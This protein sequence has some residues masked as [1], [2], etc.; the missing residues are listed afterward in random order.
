MKR[1]LAALLWPLLAPLAHAATYT[2]PGALPPGCTG[3]G[4][5]Y[6]C[7]ALS[8]GYNDVIVINSPKP[9]TLTINGN[10]S[11]DTSQ[12]RSEERRVGKEC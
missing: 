3:S 12:I 8:L 7:P 1:H 6:S 11:T 10:L 5:S 9:A 4:P 2:L